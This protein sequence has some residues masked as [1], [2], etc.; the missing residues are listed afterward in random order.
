MF[1]VPIH[2]IPHTVQLEFNIMFLSYNNDTNIFN[3]LLKQY[4]YLGASKFYIW[5]TITIFYFT[6]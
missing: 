1:V 2:V 5:A 4:F 3:Y 6:E